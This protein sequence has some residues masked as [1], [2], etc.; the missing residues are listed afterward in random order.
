MEGLINEDDESCNNSWRRWDSYEIADH[1]QEERE[2]EIGKCLHLPKTTK[3]TRSNTPY[4]EEGNTPYSSYMEIKYSGR[5]QTWSLLQE[6]PDMSYPRHW[7]RRV[8]SSSSVGRP[9]SK[10]TNLKKSVLL[11]TKSKS[12]STN[13]KKD[14]S[15]VSLVSN[16]R[17]TLNLNVSKSNENV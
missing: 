7:I 3:E 8:A 5:Y 1:D 16:K 2:Y 17:D 11:N 13:V 14:Q 6:T 9:E 12:T 4:P 10:D 15:S